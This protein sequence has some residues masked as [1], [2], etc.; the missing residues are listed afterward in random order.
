[1]LTI[2]T[3]D[4]LHRL[5]RKRKSLE[6][7]QY[8]GEM[9]LIR[10]QREHRIDVAE[11]LEDEIL[12]FYLWF[13]LNEDADENTVRER[14]RQALKNAVRRETSMDRTLEEHLEVIADSIAATTVKR[15]KDPFTLSEDRAKESAEDVANSVW[16]YREFDDAL[17][18]G[19]RFKTWI[20]MRD[21]RV[22]MDHDIADGQM[23]QITEAFDVGGYPMMYPMDDS[24]GAPLEEII[25]C[26]CTV[27]Y[28]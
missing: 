1:M 12:D 16:N 7:E 6:F 24:L 11:E 14:A 2:T 23:V 15:K 19:K 13:T 28:T 22:R 10:R 20:S 3:F 17:V 18:R 5:G 25:G 8:F 9:A 27:E 26:R 4:E 21:D